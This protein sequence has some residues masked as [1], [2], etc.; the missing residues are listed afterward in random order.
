M[1][2]RQLLTTILLLLSLLV[3]APLQIA[4]KKNEYIQTQKQPTITTDASL[5]EKTI[6]TSPTPLPLPTQPSTNVQQTVKNSATQG[7]TNYNL[8]PCQDNQE[9]GC[10]SIKNAPLEEMATTAELN[11]AVNN[12]RSSHS[13]NT[14][15]IDDQL[16]RI[17]DQ[18]AL[19]AYQN[20]N[21]DGFRQHIEAG[22]Y[23]STGY[24]SIAENLWQGE[25]SGVHIVEF[26]WDKSPGHRQNL[27]GDWDK[28]C[29]GVAA[30]TAVY[31]FLK[32]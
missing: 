29:A 2:R 5:E 10:Y 9:E 22:H 18:R 1:L 27:Q 14:L 19:E 24:K 31:I 25:F 12:Y 28:G 11:Q 7:Q 8:E 13:R 3:I 21:H 23:D 30:N 26:G 32:Q 17:A 6:Q 20:F 15:Q 4:R 16:C